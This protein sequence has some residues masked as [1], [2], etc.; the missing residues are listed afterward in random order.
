MLSYTITTAD[1]GRRL[2]SFLQNLLPA[3]PIAYLRKLTR[4]GG[5][6]VNGKAALPDLFLFVGDRLELKE[7]GRTR[8]LLATERPEL[9]ILYEDEWLVVVNKEAGLP[10]HKAAEDGGLN[11]V[12][13][14]ER[15]FRQRATMLKLRPVNRLDRGTSGGAMLAKSSTSAGMFG[16]FVKEVGLT[17]VYLAVVA[18]ELPVEGTVSTPLDGKEAQTRFQRLWQ[19]KGAALAAVYPVTGRTHQIRKHLSMTGHPILGDRRY[20]GPPLADYPGH[21]LHAWGLSFRHPAREEAVSLLAPLPA[22]FLGFLEEI[23]G[24]G[25]LLP[26]LR[27]LPALLTGATA[28]DTCRSEGPDSAGFRQE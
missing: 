5:C 15:F 23:T 13:L 6:T 12:V 8:E 21:L 14:A 11:L 17:K 19:G 7:S 16:R 3:A 10:M 22:G 9:D 2:E 25:Y 27:E 26:L 4:A 1:H 18:G 28:R 24:A 20:G